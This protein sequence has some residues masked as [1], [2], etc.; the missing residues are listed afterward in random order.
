MLAARGV[1]F[2]ELLQPEFK[3]YAKQVCANAKALAEGCKDEGMRLI[4]GGT[5]THMVMIDVTPLI[6]NGF[7]AETLLGSVG[8]VANKNMIPY[9]P[10][11]LAWEADCVLAVQP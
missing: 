11:P 4:T 9:E 3:I 2:L 8:I 1:L 7:A 5:D 6:E 10:C